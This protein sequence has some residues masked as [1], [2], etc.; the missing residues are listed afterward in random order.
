MLET[1]KNKKERIPK[2]KNENQ[3]RQAP[4][5][6]LYIKLGPVKPAGQPAS[7]L[8]CSGC[9]GGMRACECSEESSL[10]K[11]KGT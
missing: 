1:V 7:C 11:N 3:V 10:R 5:F 4:L 6:S 8:S 2:K 9:D